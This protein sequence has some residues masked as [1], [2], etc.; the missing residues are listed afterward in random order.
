MQ[1]R[2]ATLLWMMFCFAGLMAQ[3]SKNIDLRFEARGDFMQERVDGEKNSQG[4][5]FKGHIVDVF[6]QGEISPKFSY[7]YRQRLNGINKEYTFFDATDWLYLRYDLT[8]NIGLMAGKWVVLTGGWEFDPAPIDC[9]H[10]G[11]FTYNFPC[12]Q[13]GVDFIYT[14]PSKNDQ[15]YMQVTQSPF[16]KSYEHTTGKASDMYAYNLM[17]Y[18]NHRWFHSCWSVNMMEYEPG[19]Y[20]NY[21]FLGNRF[22]ITSRLRF[23]FDVLNRAAKGQRFLFSDCSIIGSLRY[24]PSDKLSVSARASYD[25]NQSGTKADGCLHDGTEMKRVGALAEYYPLGTNKIRFHAQYSYSFG[26]NTNPEGVLRDRQS[27]VDVGVTWR[28]QIL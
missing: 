22:D 23:D 21:I 25:V 13:W 12:Y 10:L 15:V 17:W 28:M 1:L 7:K 9:Y 8:P 18:G 26:K 19:K 27:I 2:S 4:S 24:S 20:I 14:S 11:E 5:G 6:L 3:K 16:R